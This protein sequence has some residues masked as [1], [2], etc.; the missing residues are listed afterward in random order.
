MFYG[1]CGSGTKIQRALRE[2]ASQYA[3][4]TEVD[5]ERFLE[6]IEKKKLKVADG[7]KS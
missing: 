3:D 2:F 4:Q 6:A 5:Y 1:Y 7:P